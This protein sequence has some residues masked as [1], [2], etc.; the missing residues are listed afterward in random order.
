MTDGAYSFLPW[1]RTGLTTRITGAPGAGRATIPVE[2]ELTGDALAPGGTAPHKSVV[3]PVQLYGPGDVIGIDPRVISRMEPPPFATNFEPNYLAHVEFYEEDFA[4]RYSPAAPAAT[5]RLTPWL[6]LV[7][8]AAAGKDGPAEFEDGEAATG[9]LPFITVTAPQALQPPGELGAFAHVH[10]NGALDDDL[11]V[12][13]STGLGTALSNLAAVLRDAPDNACSRVLCPRHLKP[14][15]RYH[16]FL[17]PAFETGR[18]AGLGIEPGEIP[19]TTPSWGVPGAP[20]SGRLPYYHRWEF[21]TSPAGDFEFLVRLLK[22]VEAKEPVGLRDVDAHR[23]PGFGLPGLTTPTEPSGVLRL[24]GALRL[25]DSDDVIDLHENWDNYYGRQKPSDPPAPPYPNQW[26]RALAGLIN[27]AEAYQHRSAEA[28]NTALAGQIP[29]LADEVDPVIT[30][31]LYGRWHALTP[32]LLAEPDGTPLPDA[33]VR[34]WVH[35]LNLDPRYR[36]AAHFGTKVIQARQEELMAAAWEQLGEARRANAWIRAA[37]LAREVGNVLHGKH[38]AEQT[39]VVGA[40]D[41]P[42]PNGRALTITAPA[43]PKV[44]DRAGPTAAAAEPGEVVAVGYKVSRSRVATAPLSPTMRR[45]TRPGSR[46]MKRLDTSLDTLVARIDEQEVSAAPSLDPPPGLVTLARSA[47]RAPAAESGLRAVDERL[48]LNVRDTTAAVVTGLDANTTIVDDIVAAVNLPAR[49]A[50]K[51]GELTEVMAYPRFDTP[52]YTELLRM[53]TDTFVPNLGLLP[54]NSITL[55]ENDRRFIESYLVGLN[56]E[57]ARELLWREYPTDQRGTPFRQF[58]DPRTAPARPNESAAA[59]RERLYDIP[60]VH[61][62]G[63]GALLGENPNP[64]PVPGSPPRESGLVLVIRGELL[65][66]YPT[67]AIYAHR[68]EWPKR[69]DPPGGPDKS[70]ER[71]LAELPVGVDPPRNLVRLPIYEAKAD[72]DIYLLGFDLGADEARGG[73]GDLGWFFVLK[74]RPGDPRFGLDD[75]QPGGP[76]PVEVW[77]D[78][79]WG[80]V[81]PAGS[82]FIRFDGAV[83]VP[84]ADFDGDEDD[85]EKERQRLDDQKVTP[86]QPDISAADAAYILFQAP[87]LVAVHAQEML[88]DAA[89]P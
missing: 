63:T 75:D 7:V 84:L 28:A 30:P 56:H 85:Q 66:K 26:Q 6:A 16:A 89:Q 69:K 64:R 33:E 58:W 74:E 60:P 52:M 1:L 82:G 25:P 44:L 48:R 34:N 24:G 14:S 71:V 15:T 20:A 19:A 8:L 67:A 59:R 46:L 79:S 11:V 2:L 86:W 18:R 61:E 68:A 5:G 38:I 51:D 4:W 54:P 37:Q 9:P 21:A 50:P 35:R 27:L 45:I 87:V 31:P 13:D 73:G 10:V 41:V 23:S 76:A 3:R 32:K 29:D 78:L 22:P 70:G 39:G 53:S 62:W 77:N 80:R 17:V 47:R 83:S 43:H 40:A 12:D 36:I 72:P 88:P 42:L 49:L 65:R 81:D 57:M 55:L